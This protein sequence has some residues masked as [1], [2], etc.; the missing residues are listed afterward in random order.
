VEACE[1]VQHELAVLRVA[2][3]PLDHLI[4]L[5]ALTGFLNV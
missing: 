2:L 4:R 3:Y 1:R 5:H